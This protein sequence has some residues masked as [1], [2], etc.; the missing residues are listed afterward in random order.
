VDKKTYL[1]Y[2]V[3][4]AEAALKYGTSLN[5]FAVKVL[6]ALNAI[7]RIMDDECTK[8]KCNIKHRH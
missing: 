3:N 8:C 5:E 1:Q 6:A 7:V 4:E 2:Y